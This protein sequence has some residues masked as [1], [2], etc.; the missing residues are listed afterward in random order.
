MLNNLSDRVGKNLIFP[1]NW[2]FFFLKEK[3]SL[4]LNIGA[5]KIEMY[6]M[7]LRKLCVIFFSWTALSME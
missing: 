1:R 7:F 5:H 4:N 3:T 6:F 2:G